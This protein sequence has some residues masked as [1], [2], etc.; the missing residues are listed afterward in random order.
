M[1]L[2]L[3]DKNEAVYLSLVLK[4]V[5]ENKPLEELLLGLTEKEKIPEILDEIKSFIRSKLDHPILSL[6]LKEMDV[7]LKAREMKRAGKTK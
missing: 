6:A 2:S 7:L 1:I 4:S 5:D 3:T